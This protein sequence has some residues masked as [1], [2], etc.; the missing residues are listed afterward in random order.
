M[1]HDVGHRLKVCSAPVGSAQA[2]NGDDTATDGTIPARHTMRGIIPTAERHA[3]LHESLAAAV[4]AAAERHADGETVATE[5]PPL[6]TL[7]EV[8]ESAEQAPTAVSSQQQPV[9]QQVSVSEPDLRG[10][11]PEPSLAM[12]IQ[13][14]RAVVS[15]E[16]GGNMNPDNETIEFLPATTQG[17]LGRLLRE[18][19]E[20]SDQRTVAQDRRPGQVQDSSTTIKVIT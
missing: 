1:S 8:T 5:S 9:T 3:L 16:W 11:A 13:R 19:G 2:F 6:R 12:D 18:G 4:A 20:A 17:E 14:R 10:S 15:G 7:P